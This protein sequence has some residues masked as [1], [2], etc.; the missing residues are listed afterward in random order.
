MQEAKQYL[1]KLRTHIPVQ[2]KRKQEFLN[3]IHEDVYAYAIEHP[4]AKY[5]DYC[6]R[7]GKPEEVA[8][9][10]ISEMPYPELYRK[11]HRGQQ[12]FVTTV[13]LAV[14]VLLVL[15]ST[16]AFMIIHNSDQ[17]TGYVIE[18]IIEDNQEK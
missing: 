15:Y 18:E 6:D 2:K 7:F 17:E 16:I 8:I 4:A 11:L 1:R 5:N 9:S 14:V 3:R 10:F 13:I 12:L